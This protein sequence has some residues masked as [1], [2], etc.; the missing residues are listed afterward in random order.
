[1]KYK[2]GRNISGIIKYFDLQGAILDLNNGYRCMNIENRREK[3][4]YPG[5]SVSRTISGYDEENMWILIESCNNHKKTG[6]YQPF[7]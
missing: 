4:L 2:K 5:Y 3:P 1:M 7:I 6:I